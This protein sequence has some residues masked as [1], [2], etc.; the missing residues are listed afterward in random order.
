MTSHDIIIQALQLKN[1]PRNLSVIST[2][3]GARVSPE[4]PK[5]A[6]TKAV[7][8]VLFFDISKQFGLV[9]EAIGVTN[10]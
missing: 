7:L 2:A 9:V 4:D 3:K 1:F 5:A 6:D 8:A 10:G